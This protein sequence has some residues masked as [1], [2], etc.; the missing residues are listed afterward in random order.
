MRLKA[1]ASRHYRHMLGTTKTL[2]HADL[3]REDDASK[4]A[5]CKTVG[6]SKE[7]TEEHTEDPG[8]APLPNLAVYENQG[9]A[10]AGKRRGAGV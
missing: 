1:Q 7:H 6:F 8:V 10:P 5:V 9:S 3:D 4:G 2:R